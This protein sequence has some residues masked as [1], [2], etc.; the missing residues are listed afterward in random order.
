MSDILDYIRTRLEIGHP[1]LLPS[2]E[3]I[4]SDA[5]HQYGGD[6]VYVRRPKSRRISTHG[7]SFTVA[8]Q[9]GVS[10]RTAQRWLQQK[11]CS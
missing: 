4:L 2:V 6:D 8:L 3:P 11:S 1:E 10:R 7:D 9:N 5:R